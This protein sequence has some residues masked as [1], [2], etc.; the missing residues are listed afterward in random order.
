MR[1]IA[2]LISLLFLFACG[3]TTP[4]DG[5]VEEKMPLSDEE[6][7][8]NAEQAIEEAEMTEGTSEDGDDPE[9]KIVL[10]ADNPEIS[11][12]QDFTALTE[13][14]SIEDDKEILKA[15]KEKFKVIEPTALPSR[16][17]K[18]TNVV[19]Y[20]LK[21]KNKVGEKLYSRLNPLGKSLSKRACRNYRLPD[22]AQAAFLEAGGPKTDRKNLDPDG[23]GFACDWSPEVYRSLVKS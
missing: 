12:T 2:L 23:D 14:V 20:A 21:T 1:Q 4:N 8:A 18:T 15:Q 17:G 10:T 6:V 5:V 16:T 11:D 7:I 13:R 9:K 19:E 22:D 3:P